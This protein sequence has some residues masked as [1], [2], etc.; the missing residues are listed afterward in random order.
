MNAR[1]LQIDQLVNRNSEL[2]AQIVALQQE[3]ASFKAQLEKFQCGAAGGSAS[4]IVS[5]APAA[6]VLQRH[7][8][9]P[10]LLALASS[11][12]SLSLPSSLEGCSQRTAAHI[13]AC[14]ITYEY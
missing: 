13:H 6:A 4:Q 3:R 7:H 11:P 12:S 5:S 10:L 2:E 9:S 1:T 8:E 14:I